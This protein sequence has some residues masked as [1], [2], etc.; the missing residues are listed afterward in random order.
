MAATTDTYTPAKR[1]I[2]L[3]RIKARHVVMV[4]YLAFMLI[5]IYWLV[6]MSLQTNR[7]ILGGFTF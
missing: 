7:E 4:L 2:A 6:K 3:P 1:A 5:P